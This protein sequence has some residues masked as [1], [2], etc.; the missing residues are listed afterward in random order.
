MVPWIPIAG[1][2]AVFVSEYSV[3]DSGRSPSSLAA[4]FA[5]IIACLVSLSG[6]RSDIPWFNTD[7][8]DTWSER[9]IKKRTD[10]IDDGNGDWSKL[11]RTL[12]VAPVIAALG[13][14]FYAEDS[15]RNFGLLDAARW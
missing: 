12:A 6:Y 3:I 2:A 11:W 5:A 13:I 9:Q 4:Y 7:K 8:G 1:S 10:F 15:F 14:T